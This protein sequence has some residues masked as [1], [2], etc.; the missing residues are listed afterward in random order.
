MTATFKIANTVQAP[1]QA[2]T[3]V[4]E[5]LDGYPRA[6][7]VVL[8][9]SEIVTNAVKYGDRGSDHDMVLEVRR[10]PGSVV[11]ELSYRG[12]P[13]TRPSLEQNDTGGFGFPIIDRLA[14]NWDIRTEGETIHA[15]FEI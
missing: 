4:R 12:A 2:R 5:A 8:A 3:A 6:D 9:T 15:W 1:H 14:V 13:F 10:N 11:V 7:D